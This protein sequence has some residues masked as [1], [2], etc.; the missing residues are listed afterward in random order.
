VKT[1]KIR[2]RW[3]LEYRVDA[4]TREADGSVTASVGVPPAAIFRDL[5]AYLEITADQILSSSLVMERPWW[6]FWR[7]S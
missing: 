3:R 6:R 7:R 4:M 5:F 1:D 2:Y